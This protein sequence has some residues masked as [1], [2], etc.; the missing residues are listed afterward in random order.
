MVMVDGWVAGV[1]ATVR[2]GRA[3]GAGGKYRRRPVYYIYY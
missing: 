2:N 3:S 1:S